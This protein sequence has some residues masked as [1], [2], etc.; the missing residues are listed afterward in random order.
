MSGARDTLA[1]R[2]LEALMPDPPG[3]AALLPHLITWLIGTGRIGPRTLVA[4][5]VPWLGR[6]V[7]LALLGSRG[8]TSAFELKLSGIQRVLEQASY[9][10]SSFNRSWVVVG[11]YPQSN[12]LEWVDRLGL[13]LV[14]VR[15]SAV[16]LVARPRSASRDP[17]LSRRVRSAIVARARIM[18]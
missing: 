17:E 7:D 8:T 2:H 6:R 13:G 15:D 1:Q 9:N 5:E 16:R 14:V 3:E 4:Y 10:G 11:S 12:A 18:R